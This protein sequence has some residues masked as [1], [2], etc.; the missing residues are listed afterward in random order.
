MAD[1]LGRLARVVHP[2]L[3]L[4]AYQMQ[5]EVIVRIMCNQGRHRSVSIGLALAAYLHCMGLPVY[6]YFRGLDR[7]RYEELRGPCGCP[8]N[9]V[10]VPD[11]SAALNGF[12]RE[13]VGRLHRAMVEEVLEGL[14]GPDGLGR[15][16]QSIESAVAASHC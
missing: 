7:G 2:Q 11:N 10:N 9:C 15:A 4:T 6:L 13:A 1:G 8:R 16:P 12:V 3:V 5:N 14:L